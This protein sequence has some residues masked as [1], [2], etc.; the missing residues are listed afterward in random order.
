VSQKARQRDLRRAPQRKI[1]EKLSLITPIISELDKNRILELEM[2]RL[3]AKIKSQKENLN[4]H[5]TA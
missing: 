1:T 4:E 3:A 2:P 5:K